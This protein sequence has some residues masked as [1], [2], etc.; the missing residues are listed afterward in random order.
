MVGLKLFWFQNWKGKR[1]FGSG[2]NLFNVPCG[3][4]CGQFTRSALW[5]LSLSCYFWL[6]SIFKFLLLM[7]CFSPAGDLAMFAMSESPAPSILLPDQFSKQFIAFSLSRPCFLPP[8]TPQSL[9]FFW[10]SIIKRNIFFFVFNEKLDRQSNLLPDQ[11]VNNSSLQL[12]PPVCLLNVYYQMNTFV[13]LAIPNWY[14]CVPRTECVPAECML[15]NEYI[16]YKYSF[17][18]ANKSWKIEIFDNLSNHG[19]LPKI[20]FG[21]HRLLV[22][23]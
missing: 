12:W 23:C 18:Y 5:F 21:I 7:K 15:S 10:H 13:R 16:S 11:L 22:E 9:D 2:W 4:V 1:W 6:L 20:Q 8:N 19:P 14:I 17:I 3:Q